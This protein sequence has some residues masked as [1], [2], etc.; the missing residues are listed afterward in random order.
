[1]VKLI[2]KNV[3]REIRHSRPRFFALMAIFA[4]GVGFF[5][6][7]SVTTYDMYRTM[8]TYFDQSRFQD[9]QILSSYGFSQAEIEQLREKPEV[10]AAAGFYSQDAVMESTGGTANVKILSLSDQVNTVELVEGRLPEN[11]T[12]CVLDNGALGRQKPALGE[13]LTV[14]EDNDNAILEA[15]HTHAFTVVGYVTSPV[16][17]SFQRGTSTVGNGKTDYFIMTTEAVFT[18]EVYSE[19]C[20]TLS[21]AAALDCYGSAYAALVD[22]AE[23][24][25]EDPALKEAQKTRIQ[26]PLLEE[27]QEN[28][29]RLDEEIANAGQELQ[30]AER[31][32]TGALQELNEAKK[33]ID[34]GTSQLSEAK[35]AYETQKNAAD[36]ALYQTNQAL[37]QK[38]AEYE[39]GYSAWQQGAAAVAQAREQLA[40]LQAAIDALEQLGET[41]ELAAMREQYAAGLEACSQQEALLAETEQ[42]L[43]SAKAALEEG[44]QALSDQQIAAEAQFSQAE[45]TLLEEEEKLLS[46][47]N[48]YNEGLTAYSRGRAEYQQ[49]QAEAGQAFEESRQK[50]DDAR[51]EIDALAVPDWYLLDRSKNLGAEGFRQDALR[52]HNIAQVFP[53][54]FFLV[55]ALVCMTTMTRMVDEQRTQMGTLKALGFGKGVI[56]AQLLLYSLAACLTGSILGLMA[57]YVVFPKAIWSAYTILYHLPSIECHFHLGYAFLSVFLAAGLSAVVTLFS[58]MNFL[59]ES[60][61]QLMRPVAPKNGKKVLLERIPFLWRLLNFTSKV[62]ARNLFRYKKRFLMTV[63]GIS[64]CTALL[65]TGFGLRDSIMG[66]V[67]TQYEE[68]YHYDLGVTLLNGD[69]P[70][71]EKI[72]SRSEQALFY[73]QDNL[74][75]TDGT[76]QLDCYALIPEDTAML[77]QMITL[78]TR[79]GHEPL[80]LDDRGVLISEKLANSFSLHIG[81]SITLKKSDE[82]SYQAVIAGI[83]ENYI[84]SYVYFTPAYYREVFAKE[85]Q[86]LSCMVKTGALDDYAVAEELLTDPEISS[87]SRVRDLLDNFNKIFS[88]LNLVVYVLIICASLLAFIVLY[89][90]TN[91]NITERA[92]ELA[93]IKVLGFFDREVDAYLYRENIILTV[94][95]CAAGLVL[96]IFLHRFVITTAEVDMV[97]F[98]R[99]VTPLSFLFSAILTFVF[100]AFVNFVMHFRLK[101]VD[102]TESLKSVE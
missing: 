56:A 41:P 62:T 7:L 65:V 64:G 49:K 51:A 93:T 44:R 67:P 60:A 81:D 52:I 79:R 47:K 46:A 76:R 59:R 50:L 86:F 101:K 25:L 43:A 39:E 2:L 23:S 94:I 22:A 13:V 33:Q 98:T 84:Y 8:D 27:W 58:A 97:M 88:S 54:L 15:L 9:L 37:A 31:R 72:T 40:E 68:I 30:A 85:P 38:Q 16:Y 1:M 75:A 42:Q 91:I 100:A 26:A 3:R 36:T 45:A 80:T 14:S 95:G 18:A 5:A 53:V 82:T 71:R 74:I 28:K 29:N 35:T 61:A 4:L 102:M 11:E 48:Q 90:L 92:R 96:G 63:L 19:A 99:T 10:E 57:G 55:A 70:V 24:T 78:R 73:A 34:A 83:T 32:L 77:G 21:G 20:L 89:N 17:L 12:E 6:G 87:V 69:A 66:I